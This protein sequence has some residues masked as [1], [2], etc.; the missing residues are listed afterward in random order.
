MFLNCCNFIQ[1]NK[2]VDNK[3]IK[4]YRNSASKLILHSNIKNIKFTVLNKYPK[5][6]ENN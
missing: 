6:L 1:L 4:Q 3:L 2:Y 5:K